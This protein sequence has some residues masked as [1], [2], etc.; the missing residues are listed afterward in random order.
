MRRGDDRGRFEALTGGVRSRVGQKK[1]HRRLSTAFRWAVRAGGR[2]PD[3]VGN[4][5]AKQFLK[6]FRM[7]W[8]KGGHIHRFLCDFARAFTEDPFGDRQLILNMSSAR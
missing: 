8:L 3:V 6:F 7:I 2:E 4:S 5:I 1:S